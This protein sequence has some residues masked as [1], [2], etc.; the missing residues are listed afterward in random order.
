MLCYYIKFDYVFFHDGQLM[1]SGLSESA[2]R[3]ETRA[4]NKQV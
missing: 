3:L 2:A 4:E 1:F